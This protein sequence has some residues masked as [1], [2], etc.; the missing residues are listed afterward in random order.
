VQVRTP[1]PPRGSGSRTYWSPSRGSPY[2]LLGSHLTRV[3]IRDVCSLPLLVPGLSH[4]RSQCQVSGDP[5]LTR[6][7]V[8]LPL[9]PAC[10]PASLPG[11]TVRGDPTLPPA[12]PPPGDPTLPRGRPGPTL[13]G[14]LR[15]ISYTPE[16][17]RPDRSEDPG[18]P[19]KLFEAAVPFLATVGASEAVSPG[20][21]TSPGHTS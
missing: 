7:A 12:R 8:N 1:H 18:D 16:R 14:G 15:F 4:L 9:G 2:L 20:Y 5:G 17:E 19:R 11:R 10:L 21:R 3:R 13:R 6:P